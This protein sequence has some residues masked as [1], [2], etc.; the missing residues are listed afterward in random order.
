MRNFPPRKPLPNS[1]ADRNRR[2]KV[3]ARGSCAS[4]DSKG[5]TDSEAPAYLEDAAEG[6][7]ANGGGSVDGK[8]S[9]SCDTGEDVEEDAC[10]FG[11]AFSK[12]SRPGVLEVELPLRY[13][14]RCDNMSGVMLLD[15]L[16]GTN[17]HYCISA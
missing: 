11:H 5:D 8:G 13:R 6:G 14:F 10:G 4:D 2:I 12:D 16:G 17:L 1:E 3:T 7:D 9:D 15:S